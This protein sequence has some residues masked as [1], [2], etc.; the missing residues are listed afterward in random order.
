MKLRRAA[1]LLLA[2]PLA[3]CPG[4]YAQQKMQ[5]DIDGLKAQ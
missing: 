4:P 5:T 3:G 2:L 1:L